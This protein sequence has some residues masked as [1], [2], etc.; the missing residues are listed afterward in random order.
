MIQSVTM[1]MRLHILNFWLYSSPKNDILSTRHIC[2]T[3]RAKLT[4][5]WVSGVQIWCLGQTAAC[6]H[7]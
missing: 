4:A 3:Y 6:K 2:I 1:T 5:D 7:C